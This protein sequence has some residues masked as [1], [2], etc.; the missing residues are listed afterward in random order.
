LHDIYLYIFGEL[1]HELI[2]KASIKFIVH[3]IF[4][5]YFHMGKTTIKKSHP[6]EWK[7][8]KI[9]FL[10]VWKI[11]RKHNSLDCQIFLAISKNFSLITK[12]TCSKVNTIQKCFCMFKALKPQERT[13]LVFFK[14]PFFTKC[15]PLILKIEEYFNIDD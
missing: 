6:N 4:F 13:I 10:Y 11:T 7:L 12:F 5:K 2:H 15:A 9:V 14:R 3:G 8:L 1:N